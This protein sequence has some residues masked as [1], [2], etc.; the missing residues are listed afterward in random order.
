MP[1][2]LPKSVTSTTCGWSSRE[3]AAASRKNRVVD[4]GSVATLGLMVFRA[5]G[6]AMPVWTAS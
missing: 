4:R 3:A 5:T 6:L 2:S 1:S